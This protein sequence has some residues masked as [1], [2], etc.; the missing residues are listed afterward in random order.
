MKA[1]LSKVEI[2]AVF[3]SAFLALPVGLLLSG[4]IEKKIGLK[5]TVFLAG[6]LLGLGYV[7]AGLKVEEINFWSLVFGIGVLGGFGIG[8][9]YTIPISLGLK[10]FPDKPG[11]ISGI[12]VAGFGLGSMFWVKMADNWGHFLQNLGL[13]N[14]FLFFGCAII[15]I[16]LICSQFLYWP[17]ALLNKKL[18]KDAEKPSQI[19]NSKNYYLI[20]FS[21]ALSTAA[22]LMVLALMKVFLPMVLSESFASSPVIIAS[23]AIAYCF[24]PANALGRIFWGKI[25]DFLEPKKTLVLLCFSQSFCILVFYFLAAKPAGLYIA[26]AMVGLNFGGNFAVFPPLTASVFG[27]RHFSLH[28]SK[29]ILGWCVGGFFGPLLGGIFSFYGFYKGA[30]YLAAFQCLLAAFLVMALVRNNR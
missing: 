15:V 1:G 18:D 10:H 29:V 20:L 13:Q 7:L 17:K 26:S 9:G 19:L 28:Y 14:T 12:T 16:T 21:F 8:L 24:A 22:G 25:C 23:N 30:Y 3:S 6:F 11:L 27:S 4:K 5:L 2:Q